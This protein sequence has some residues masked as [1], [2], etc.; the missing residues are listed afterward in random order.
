MEGKN[1]AEFEKQN[2]IESVGQVL[3]STLRLGSVPRFRVSLGITTV[4][5][6]CEEWFGH[7]PVNSGIIQKAAMES[8]ITRKMA[9]RGAVFMG[10]NPEDMDLV[11]L[12]T[13]KYGL[14]EFPA[15]AIRAGQLIVVRQPLPLPRKPY[16]PVDSL[17]KVR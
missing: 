13:G 5:S 17:L 1:M 15:E 7:S 6:F 16:I 9:M 2:Y 14:V 3:E 11:R 10:L 8:V 12:L 4:N